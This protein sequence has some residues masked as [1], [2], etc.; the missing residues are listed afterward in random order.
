MPKVPGYVSN[1]GYPKR[2]EISLQKSTTKIGELGHVGTENP[3]PK[4][5]AGWDLEDVSMHVEPTL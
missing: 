1:F 3:T 4:N 5:V 2:D